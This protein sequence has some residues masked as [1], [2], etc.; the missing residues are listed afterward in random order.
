MEIKLDK[1]TEDTI[2]SNYKIAPSVFREIE[3]RRISSEIAQNSIS[4]ILQD[5]PTKPSSP[6]QSNSITTQL[7]NDANYQYKLNENQLKAVL[8][9]LSLLDVSIDKIDEIIKKLDIKALPLIDEINIAIKNVELA[10]N[11]VIESGCKSNL[12]WSRIPDTIWYD[13]I[14]GPQTTSNY[15]V[16][17]DPAQRELLRYYGI[18]YYQKPLNRDYGYAITSE[19]DASILVGSYNLTV[20]G[21]GGT[22]GIQ[23]GDEITDNINSPE[24]FNIGSLPTVVGFGTTNILGITTTIVGNISIGSSTIAYTGIGSTENILIGNYVIN[25]DVF[26]SDTQV[27]GFNTTTTII[28]YTDI[29]SSTSITTS[30]VVP[31]IALS[32][33]SISSITNGSIGFGTYGEYDSIILSSPSNITIDNQLFTAIR[34]DV[35]ITTNF[36]YTNNPIDPVTVGIIN[37]QRVGIGHKAQLIH[38]ASNPGPAQWREVFGEPEPNIGAGTL[39][40]YTGVQ[41]W[42]YNPVIG[43][44]SEDTIYSFSGVGTPSYTSISPTGISSSTCVSYASSIIAVE[45]ELQRIINKNVPQ[46]EKFITTSL[47]LRSSRDG[48]ESKAWSYL[49]SASYLRSKMNELQSNIDA[50]KSFDY[51]SL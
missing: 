22:T 32:K 1:S 24:A 11:K 39:S 19:F 28:T 26:T 21:A 29:G 44:A 36:N 45:D 15:E 31:G 8:D 20:L 23:T 47:P 18:R 25:P 40:Y 3:Q 5:S 12:I 13:A 34:K 51:A 6:E 48:E 14:A 49:Q 43:Y 38:N 9:I 41:S 7:I 37:Y 35:D 50:L 46:I 2:D 4:T 17:K 27:I 30:I 10:Y 33:V 42:P 16:V